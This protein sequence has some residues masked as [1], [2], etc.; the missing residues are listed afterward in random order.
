MKDVNEVPQKIIDQMLTYVKQLVTISPPN[1][2]KNMIG[3][4]D[5]D[6][7]V[8]KSYY[9]GSVV[10]PC[11]TFSQF[12]DSHLRWCAKEIRKLRKYRHLAN[13]LEVVRRELSQLVKENP[14]LDGL[15][16]GDA[17]T[18]FH[19]D[20]NASNILIDPVTHDI[21]GII[22]WDFTVHGFEFNDLDLSFFGNWF[23]NEEHSEDMM[24]RVERCESDAKNDLISFLSKH[25]KGKKYRRLLVAMVIDASMMVFYCSSWFKNNDSDPINAI[26]DLIDK[27]ANLLDEDLYHWPHLYMQL[28]NYKHNV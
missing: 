11:R 26:A 2:D 17:M 13:D 19:G 21:T 23:T 4:F 12:V 6:M 10:E 8:S 5:A 15:N 9:E 22:D 28:K 16:F 27:H 25:Q 3:F 1:M 7:N 24:D 20:L 14:D 18:V